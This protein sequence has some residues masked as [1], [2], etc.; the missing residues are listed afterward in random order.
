MRAGRAWDASV[1]SASGIVGREVALAAV[2]GLI[3]A[4]RTGLAALTGR[5][6]HLALS[7][8]AAQADA[9]LAYAALGDLLAPIEP[10]VFDRLPDSAAAL[11]LVEHERLPMPLEH[12]LTLLVLGQLQRRRGKR[13]AA[14][15]TLERALGIFEE[16]GAPIWAERARAESRRIGVRRAPTELTESERRVAELAAH[17]LTNPGIAARLFVSRRTVEANLARAYRVTG[18]L[19]RPPLTRLRPYGPRCVSV[20]ACPTLPFRTIP[21]STTSSIPVT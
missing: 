5:E 18:R 9:R 3:A 16:L 20:L 13:K 21:P 12:G 17:G 14:R 4:A 2:D 10:P 1:V 15:E 19:R 7:C 8:R 11:A 6:G